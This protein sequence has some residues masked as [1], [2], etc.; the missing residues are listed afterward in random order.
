[1]RPQA[2]AGGGAPFP[3]RRVPAGT[4]WGDVVVF[5]YNAFGQL[6]Y[7][8]TGAAQS[9]PRRLGVRGARGVAVGDEHSALQLSAKP[10]PAR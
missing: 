6:M 10:A 9:T 7:R 1:M 8:S 3:R 5:G 4:S 2:M